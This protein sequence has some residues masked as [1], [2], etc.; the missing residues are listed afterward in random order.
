M[1][2]VVVHY[3]EIGLK[4]KN[5]D[6]FEYKL[7]SNLRGA[8]GRISSGKV[9]RQYG[10]IVIELAKGEETANIKITEKLL[11]VAGISNFSF[12]WGSG[13]EMKDI[14]AS[15]DKAAK[16]KK[17][18]TFALSATRS[19]KRFKH[20]S[21]ELKD[22]LGNHM[23]K[24]HGWKVDLSDPD[25]T[26]FIEV[27]EKM[28]FVFTEKIRGLGGLPVTASGS[29][30]S[31]ISGGIDSPVASVEMMKRGCSVIFVHFHNHT[32]DKDVVKDKVERI[33]KVLSE[34]QPKTKLYMIPFGDI[35]K[36][37]IL[38]I[39][40]RYRMIVYRRVMFEIANRIAES[41]KALGFVTGDSVGQVA[42]QTLE[43]L[44]VIYGKAKLPV[45]APLVSRNKQ[46]IVDMAKRIDT[47]DLSILPYSD[48][49]SFLIAP[50]PETRAQTSSIEKMESN[51]DL[52]KLVDSALKN[53]QIKEF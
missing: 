11:K 28:S 47:Y 5:R 29:L 15:L 4:G 14:Q 3:S 22:T 38:K 44:R 30:V 24:K 25:M 23:R 41:E 19:D 18:A 35:Q 8:L 34:Y 36:E 1:K 10:R 32:K 2:Y 9:S 6:F 16:G 31:L 17:I 37:L 42:S 45:Y 21:R 40:A 53:K 46:E 39:Q 52:D 26:F 20:T 48:C 49:C 50:H 43:N 51:I 33:V 7:I 13:R 12:A 27:T